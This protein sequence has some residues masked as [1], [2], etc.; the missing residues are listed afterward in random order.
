M[1]VARLRQWA[2]PPLPWGLRL[3]VQPPPCHAFLWTESSQLNSETFETS[4]LEKC[5]KLLQDLT[6]DS[7]T[8]TGCCRLPAWMNIKYQHGGGTKCSGTNSWF[9]RSQNGNF[10]EESFILISFCYT[11]P[12]PQA[13]CWAN[14]FSLS[15]KCQ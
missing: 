5:F 1:G 8:I 11:A 7:A 3:T 14:C 9:F 10:P 6:E 2:W 13:I 15:Q 4:R 12:P